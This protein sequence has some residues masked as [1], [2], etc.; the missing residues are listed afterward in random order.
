MS[1]GCFD[2][3]QR[4]FVEASWKTSFAICCSE[5]EKRHRQINLISQ[6]N[7]ISQN[8]FPFPV[9]NNKMTA[10]ARQCKQG[11][12]ERSPELAC[13]P[14]MSQAS[15][16][17][18][19]RDRKENAEQS[20][21]KGGV[22]TP[23]PW[24]LHDMLDDMAKAGDTSVVCWQS[25]GRAFMVHKPQVFVS[26]IMRMYFNQTKYAS[27]Q[28]QLNL[29]GFSRLS[30]GQD[31]GAYFHHCFIRGQ[32]KLCRNMIRQK[33][34]GTK[35][36][37]SLSAEEE[38]NFYAPK[39]Q[40]PDTPSPV[41]STLTPKTESSHAPSSPRFQSS[42][43]RSKKTKAQPRTSHSNSLVSMIRESTSSS[44][45]SLLRLIPTPTMI[46]PRQEPYSLQESPVQVI[47]PAARGGDLL[48][49]EGRPFRYLEH[50]EELP[51][52][53]QS[54]SF[55]TLHDM[56]SSIVKMDKKKAWTITQRNKG[57]IQSN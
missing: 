19:T 11:S 46:K 54:N 9:T 7:P 16:N 22:T 6:M 37:K 1:V 39:Y 38:P 15:P 13:S 21:A 29:Y 51:P 27:F 48:Y 45:S 34:K 12:K 50:L 43:S 17:F 18:Q 14:V 24:K 23:F 10:K 33:I 57:L 3:H 8:S 30:H 26:E 56:I 52:V 55:H 4:A 40:S 35:V 42:K 28:R 36:R 32:R 49:F 53:S 47:S 20:I 2:K 5:K 44:N 25:H 41:L 31:K